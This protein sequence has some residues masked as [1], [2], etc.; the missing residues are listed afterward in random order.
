MPTP[1]SVSVSWPGVGNGATHVLTTNLQSSPSLT[2][3][4]WTFVTNGITPAGVENIYAV[5][6]PT[7]AQFFRLVLP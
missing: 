4:T 1:G 5:P 2:A 7:G 6:S 3:Q